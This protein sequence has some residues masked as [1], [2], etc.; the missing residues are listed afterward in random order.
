[1]KI[2][3]VSLGCDKNLVD[4]EMMMGLLQK[5]GYEF[6]D[7]ETLA[8]VI[9]IN[10]CGFIND[11]KEESINTIIAMAEYKKQNLKALVVTG[12]LAERYKNEILDELPEIDAVVGT[13]A[14]DKICD[15]I[16]DVLADKKHNEFED[17]N[18]L[19]RPASERI[20]TTGGYYSYLKIAEGCDKH[21]TYCS[22]PSIRG[23]YR[24]V[25]MEDLVSEAEYLAG[26]GI[27]ELI[28]VAQETSLYGTDLYGEKK[29]P[30]L[31][32]RLCKISGIE[33][34]R[35]L[36]CYP[37]EITDELIN[38]IKTEPKVC[39]Y[40]DMPIQHAS[41]NILKRMGRR[42]DENAL[43]NII[44][45]LRREI[46]DICIRTT[47]I[48]G[49]PGET[50]KDHEV[51]MNFVDEMEFDRLGVFTYSRE[52]DTPAAGFDNQVDEEVKLTRKDELMELQQEISCEKGERLVGRTLEVIIE[53]KAVD[54]DVYVGR[55]YMD[56]PGVDGYIFIN[57]EEELMSGD[58]A[59]VKVTK[60]LEYD[61]I[62]ELC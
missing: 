6:T 56:A 48:T 57:S 47:L 41:D 17:I 2:L 9:V 24:S 13:S 40:I 8:D 50:D 43:R 29:L 12:C 23:S 7:D 59:R 58:F 46:P 10:T 38:I 1:M 22:I 21:C 27:K 52:E 5:R 53:G 45:K 25:P 26:R 33:W 37:E 60:S 61:L 39:N 15:V 44:G 42:T 54:E 20:I 55:T 62:G 14:F 16:D 19:C 35:L 3:F 31:L 11:A 32:K 30:E 34:I 4:S 18:R 36:Y 51:L 28:L 49:F